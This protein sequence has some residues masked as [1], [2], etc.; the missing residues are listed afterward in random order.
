MISGKYCKNNSECG[1]K[2]ITCLEDKCACDQEHVE[3]EN[4][5]LCLRKAKK[6]GDNCTESVQC[7]ALNGA[8]CREQKCEPLILDDVRE[9]LNQLNLLLFDFSSL[10]SPPSPP[11]KMPSNIFIKA[12]VF[13]IK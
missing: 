3:S 13:I 6:L 1:S 2:G 7:V 8:I 4:L 5:K 11:Q 9:S 12:F 10:I